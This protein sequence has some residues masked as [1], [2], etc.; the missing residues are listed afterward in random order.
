MRRTARPVI[1]VLGACVTLGISSGEGELV[2]LSSR[3][4]G[5]YGHM[6]V[7]SNPEFMFFSLKAFC[8]AG[9]KT[10]QKTLFDMFTVPNELNIISLRPFV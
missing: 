9:Q 5:L 3:M 7:F 4:F 1:G 8:Q 2:I 6:P 10:P